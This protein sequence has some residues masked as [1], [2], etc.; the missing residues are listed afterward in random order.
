M[1][2]ISD[3]IEQIEYTN[4]YFVGNSFIFWLLPEPLA[5]RNQSIEGLMLFMAE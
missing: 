4:R 3:L 5:E 2:L 1:K